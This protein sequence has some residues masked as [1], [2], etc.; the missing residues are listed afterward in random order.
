M[1]LR[2][3]TVSQFDQNMYLTTC[4]ER[5]IFSKLNLN[6]ALGCVAL[7]MFALACLAESVFSAGRLEWT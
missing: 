4:S 6:F 7:G 3:Q 5:E 2:S 1:M